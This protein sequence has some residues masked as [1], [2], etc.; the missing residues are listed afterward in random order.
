[1]SARERLQ[2]RLL[3]SR[4][5]GAGIDFK[6]KE[7]EKNDKVKAP[8]W[9]R[10][11]TLVFLIPARWLWYIIE[12]VEPAETGVSVPVKVILRVAMTFVRQAIVLARWAMCERYVV[13]GDVVEKVYLLFLQH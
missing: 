13:V 11:K 10:Q 3:S 7:R 12:F 8:Y 6:I 2:R 5:G 9:E 4:P 1:L